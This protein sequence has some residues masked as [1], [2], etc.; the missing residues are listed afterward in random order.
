MLAVER[1]NQIVKIIG[2]HG[3]VRVSDLSMRFAVTE[4]TIR[5][6][7]DKLDKEGKLVKT[8]GGA[9]QIENV[10]VDYSFDDRLT[11][12]IDEKEKIANMANVLI[13]DGETIFVDMSTTAL[14]LVKYLDESKKITVITNSFR[15]LLD[16]MG[17]PNINLISLGGTF[18]QNTN[19]FIGPTTYKVIDNYYVDKAIFSV[20]AIG[21]N[22][23][24]MDSKENLAHIKSK[25]IKN[26]RNSILLADSSKFDQ[27]ALIKVSDFKYIDTLVTTKKLNS[28]WMKYLDNN[29]VKT[30]YVK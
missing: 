5:R 16:L 14:L 15:C 27:N 1:R 3:T 13:E 23:G 25:M 20:K 6:D 29:K 28:S 10:S 22:H 19:S 11:V 18:D 4:E 7:L 8:H 21:L 26:S 12:N 24:M 9:V 30:I 17:K 2:I